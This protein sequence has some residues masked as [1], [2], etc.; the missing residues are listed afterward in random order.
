M[1]DFTNLLENSN[2]SISG[3]DFITRVQQSPEERERLLFS[4]RERILKEIA[5]LNGDEF[6]QTPQY[7]KQIK[8]ILEL[9]D[10]GFEAEALKCM[11]IIHTV[12][13]ETESSLLPWFNLHLKKFGI[14]LT[15]YHTT[16]LFIEDTMWKD[17][18]I[19][20]TW[21]YEGNQNEDN[22]KWHECAIAESDLFEYVKSEGLNQITLD[23]SNHEGEHIQSDL[24]R[25]LYAFVQDEID[26]IVKGYLQSGWPRTEL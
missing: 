24:K 25:E 22:C 15:K 4:T 13:I 19:L 10:Y 20:T 6:N 14:D 18:L 9:N 17:G 8:L 7:E 12:L 26:S 21:C 2:P 11:N 1:N 23:S 16:S 5:C 3:L